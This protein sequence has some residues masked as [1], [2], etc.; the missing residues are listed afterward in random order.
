MKSIKVAEAVKIIE[1]TQ[2][3]VN[4][5]FMNEISN[6]F[7]KL[8]IDTME[9]LEAAKTKWNFINF[10][11]GLVGGHCIGVDPFYLIEKAKKVG[12]D[13]K[14][15][16]MART[17]N[18]EMPKIIVEDIENKLKEYGVKNENAS[19]AVLGLTFKENVSDLRNSKSIEIVELLRKKGINVII[20]DPMVN[21]EQYNMKSIENINN[22]DIVI[23]AVGH[24]VY[25]K[26][27]PSDIKNMLKDNRNIIYDLK[28]IFEKELLEK[29]GIL[30]IS[31]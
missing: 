11:P 1:N 31:L 7:K 2:R 14:L 12:F 8:N 4:I 15:I 24:D 17:V 16:K 3:D 20:S 25:K 10:T 21:C 18:D 19:V 30:K 9:V 23:F 29:N 22:V 6:L 5:A 28:N 13:T 26:L 27:K